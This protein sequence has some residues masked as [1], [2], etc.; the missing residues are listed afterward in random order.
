MRTG[1]GAEQFEG[2]QSKTGDRPS[3]LTALLVSFPRYY[4]VGFMGLKIE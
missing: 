1:W 3:C 2:G 4:G